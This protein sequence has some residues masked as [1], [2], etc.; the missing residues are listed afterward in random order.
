MTNF[1]KIKNMSIDELAEKLNESFACDRCPIEEFC[2][3][4]NSGPHSSCTIVWGKWLKSE[5]KNNDISKS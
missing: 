2:N 4:N 5:V 3:E 1:E